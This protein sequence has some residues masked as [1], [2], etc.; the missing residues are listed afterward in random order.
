MPSHK[1]FR[2]VKMQATGNDFILT[3]SEWMVSVGST[4]ELSEIA[5]RVCD[6]HYGIG[7]D[8]FICLR[9]D[10]AGSG[11]L[12]QKL[13]MLF[14]N[15]DGSHSRM[16]GNG[17]RCFAK[18]A[19]MQGWKNPLH[20]TVQKNHY[21]AHSYS[22]SPEKVT[23]F[24]EEAVGVQPFDLS[25]LSEVGLV[26]QAEL[27]RLNYRVHSAY[28]VHPGTDHLV[29]LLESE[30]SLLKDFIPIG[31]S[32]REKLEQIGADIRTHEAF[33]PAGI[34]VNFARITKA[35]QLELLTYERG[36]E[37]FTESC[38]TGT[39]ASALALITA[40]MS[41][42]AVSSQDGGVSNVSGVEF[43]PQ[44]KSSTIHVN[45][46]GGRLDVD[47]GHDS[48]SKISHFHS[49]SLTGPAQ[50]IAEGS[51]NLPV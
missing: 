40:D 45:T 12:H 20:F 38:G 32:R 39:I 27:S 6:R 48:F 41:S 22:E 47:C 24:Y 21:R 46:D 3:T 33:S 26:V 31:S 23:L 19:W 11:G 17:A 4:D 8:G 7:A 34:N 2:F 16:C 5:R 51:F 44:A 14:F 43:S 1:T 13:E 36:V 9:E 37:G 18:F 25:T 49:I 15:P 30:D 29:L 10:H 50:F 28:R 35:E 42:Q